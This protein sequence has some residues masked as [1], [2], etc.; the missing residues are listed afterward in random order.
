MDVFQQYLHGREEF[1]VFLLDE[2]SDPLI[3]GVV[4]IFPALKVL[5]DILEKHG[6]GRGVHILGRFLQF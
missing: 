3:N 2:L 6:G 5:A 1:I 4:A